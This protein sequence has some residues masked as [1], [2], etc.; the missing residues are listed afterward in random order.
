MFQV[1]SI[2]VYR[3]QYKYAKVSNFL[4]NYL[5]IGS[6]NVH[7]KKLFVEDAIEEHYA[8][9]LAPTD[10]REKILFNSNWSKQKDEELF[11]E[12]KPVN[13]YY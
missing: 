1:H 12:I 9:W 4:I 13:C 8:G 6:E 7:E 2:D 5:A 10:L 3:Q 11:T